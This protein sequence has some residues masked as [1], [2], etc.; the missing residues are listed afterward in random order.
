MRPIC[1]FRHDYA[2]L[3]QAEQTQVVLSRH[4]FPLD[5]GGELPETGVLVLAAKLYGKD[6]KEVHRIPDSV[7]IFAGPCGFLPMF[8]GMLLATNL[9]TLA[10]SLTDMKVGGWHSWGEWLSALWP[11]WSHEAK[12]LRQAHVCDRVHDIGLQLYEFVLPQE[13]CTPFAASNQYR[14]NMKSKKYCSGLVHPVLAMG[15]SDTQS[16]I[17]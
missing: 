8:R 12:V 16:A 14:G 10:T 6:K 3:P 1:R 2:P 5:S 13:E 9:A 15:Q 7:A 4:V 17:L 11:K